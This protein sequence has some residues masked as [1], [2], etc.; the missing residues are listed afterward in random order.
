MS[1]SIE[2]AKWPTQRRKFCADSSLQR[3][4]LPIDKIAQE[5]IDCGPRGYY[6]CRE[7]CTDLAGLTPPQSSQLRVVSKRVAN[8]RWAPLSRCKRHLVRAL[9]LLS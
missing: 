5:R 1:C 3:T 8:L 9:I 4:R 6:D 2:I 7:V